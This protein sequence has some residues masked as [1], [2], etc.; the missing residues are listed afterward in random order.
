MEGASFEIEHGGEASETLVVGVSEFGLAGLTAVDYLVETLGLEKTGHVTTDDLPSITPFEDGRPRHHTRFFSSDEVDFTVLVGEMFVPL[1]AARSFS[2]AMTGWMAENDVSEIVFLSGIVGPHGPDQHDV[3]YVATD[4]YRNRV[5][6]SFEAMGGGF[7]EGV[8]AELLARGIDTSV[9]VGVLATPVHPPAQDV[10]AAVRLIDAFDR[11]YG[12]EVDTEPL[13]EY[14]RNL[15]QH[16]EQLS[17]R[18]RKMEEESRRRVT[19]D[20]A[21]M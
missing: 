1:D 14:A 5:E 19:E 9:A 7:F 10:D 12:V 4:D 21:Y 17:D 20:R 6:D 3:F 16:Y 13:E 2:D 11:V 8:H 18:M 15:Q